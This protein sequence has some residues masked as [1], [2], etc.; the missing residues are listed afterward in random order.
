MVNREHLKH[1]GLSGSWPEWFK[2]VLET[3]DKGDSKPQSIAK[4][5]QSKQRS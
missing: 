1:L 2:N 4:E 5:E 3:K